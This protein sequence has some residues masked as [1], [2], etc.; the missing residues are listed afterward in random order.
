MPKGSP[1][2]PPQIDNSAKLLGSAGIGVPSGAR[3][4]KPRATIA[5]APHLSAFSLSYLSLHLEHLDS[6]S[7][8]LFSLS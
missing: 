4:R 7:L 2:H 1:Q 6:R 3:P 5:E 8:R